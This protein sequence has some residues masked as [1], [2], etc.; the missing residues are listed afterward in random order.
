MDQGGG[1]GG[2]DTAAETEN[3]LLS[4]GFL[5]DFAD[6][7]FD[8]GLHGPVSGASADAHGEVADDFSSAVCVNDFGME[9]DSVDFLFGVA[10]CGEFGVRG[11]RRGD[12]S[13]GKRGD[14]VPVGHPDLKRRGE[15]VE[16]RGFAGDFDF[17]LAVFACMTA[18]DFAAERHDGQ[19]EAVADSEHGNAEVED[20]R[21]ALRG[22]VLIDACG[23]AAEDD[24]HRSFLADFFNRSAEGNDTAVNLAFTDSPRDQLAV[25]RT[26]VQNEYGFVFCHVSLPDL[27]FLRQ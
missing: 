20:F 1:N 17:R 11:F 13:F 6:A 4:G 3:D 8:E 18:G 19:L 12:E 16:K 21:I 27:K 23:S 9:L 26:E 24:S 2:V 7:A 14:F 10:D 22:I 15:P 5:L 25:L